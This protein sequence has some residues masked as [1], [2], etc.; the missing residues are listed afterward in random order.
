MANNSTPM[1]AC[2]TTQNFINGTRLS[3]FFMI[4]PPN[5]QESSRATVQ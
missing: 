3:T 4:M 2:V 1:D 5:C